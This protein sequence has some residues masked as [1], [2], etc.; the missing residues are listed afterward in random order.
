[1]AGTARAG[2]SAAM[3]GTM[4]LVRSAPPPR[5][6]ARRSADIIAM[7]P[8]FCIPGRRA[9]LIPARRLG[10]W[11]PAP[12]RTAVC[13][14]PLPSL[15]SLQGFVALA[16]AGSIRRPVSMRERS[17]HL[18]ALPPAD[19]AAASAAFISSTQPEF[20]TLARQRRRSLAGAAVCM[21]LAAL[22][23]P[24][25]V[26]PPRQTLRSEVSVRTARSARPTSALPPHQDF[27][28]SAFVASEEVGLSRAAARRSDR[29]APGI[30][31]G[32]ADRKGYGRVISSA[33]Q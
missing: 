18:R 15:A 22:R 8:S 10:A 2:I 11:A 17:P 27:R 26:H 24:T 14:R 9:L 28:A 20:R 6:S 31:S 12:F 19:S 5:S 30:G 1:M 4:V 13:T 29:P 7:A 33:T 16:Q 3:N 21:G 32:V 25:S 23:E